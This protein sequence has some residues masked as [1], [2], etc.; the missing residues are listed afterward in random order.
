MYLNSA[1]VIRKTPNIIKIPKKI[2]YQITFLLKN[3]GSIKDAK[4][5][6]VENMA[7]AIEIFASLMDAKKVIQCSAIKIPAIE[8]LTNSEKLMLRLTLL[9]LINRKIKINAITILNHTNDTA[10]IEMS[11]PRIAVNPAIKTRK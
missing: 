2:S 1:W 5:A 3:M 11:S 6:P 7:K 4:K 9:N 8:N 10:F